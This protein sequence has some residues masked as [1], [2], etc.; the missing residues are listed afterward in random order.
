MLKPRLQGTIPSLPT[1]WTTDF[2]CLLTPIVT[3]K[4]AKLKPSD[5]NHTYQPNKSSPEMTALQ[6]APDESG[7]RADL[8]LQTAGCK[9]VT[10]LLSP[11]HLAS[12]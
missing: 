2:N 3:R 8:C 1:Q 9:P 4:L 5:I 12:C 11:K 10:D 6:T 7:H